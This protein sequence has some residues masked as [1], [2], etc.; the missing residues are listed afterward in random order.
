MS[1][2]YENT[3]KKQFINLFNRMFVKHRRVHSFHK[4]DEEVIAIDLTPIKYTRSGFVVTDN[5]GVERPVELNRLASIPTANVNLI[6]LR[7]AVDAMYDKY[8]CSDMINVGDGFVKSLSKSVDKLEEACNE[9]KIKNEYIKQL[10]EQIKTLSEQ[11]ETLSHPG[12]SKKLAAFKRKE[13]KD[14]AKSEFL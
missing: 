6:E 10:E 1:W 5:H 9:L 11:V 3:D 14:F 8:F 4:E 13:A 7:S 2:L 12:Y